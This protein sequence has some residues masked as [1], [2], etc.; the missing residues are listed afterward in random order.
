MVRGARLR[1]HGRA[2]DR[3]PRDRALAARR[4]A[5]GTREVGAAL[6]RERADGDVGEIWLHGLNI[7][8]GYWNKVDETEA[9]LVVQALDR[10]GNAYPSHEEEDF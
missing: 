3:G 1:D 9:T 2:V 8:K 4:R 6:R 7:G 5:P 10:M